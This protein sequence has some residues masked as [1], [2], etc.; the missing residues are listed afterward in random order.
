MT[1]AL[2]TETAEPVSV[3]APVGKNGNPAP[4][5]KVAPLSIEPVDVISAPARMVPFR[6][7]VV[8]VTASLTHQY[9]LHGCPPPAMITVKLV[10]VR[11]PPPPVPILKIQIPLAG[12]LSVNVPPVVVD[13]AATQ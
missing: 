10:P 3:T 8:I 5:A 1:P 7:D 4:P 6:N 12:P 9:T 2:Q 11:A 13:A